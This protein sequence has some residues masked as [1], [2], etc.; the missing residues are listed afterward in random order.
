MARARRL[1][2][3]YVLGEA[4]RIVKSYDTQVTLRQLFYRLVSAEIIEN[5]QSRYN[6]LSARSAQARRDGWFPSLID[7]NRNMGGHS[8]W[9]SPEQALRTIAKAYTRDRTEHQVFG[10]YVAVEKNA[11][12]GLLE[13][14]FDELGVAIV[15]LGGYA[16]QT[17]CD[18]VAEDVARYGRDAVLI[19][20]GD[21]DPSGLDIQRDFEARTDCWHSV[22]R[23]ALS[24]EQ[25][26]QYN[27]PPL[28]GK[29]SDSRAAGFVAEHGEL[30]QVEL[31]ALPPDVL[32]SLY[33]AGID[34]WWNDEAYEQSLAQEEEERGWLTGLRF[35]R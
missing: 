20:G 3:D 28:P 14:W 26:E 12:R 22:E 4:A 33:Q 2:W 8:G 9:D 6:S 19:Y 23:V 16:S 29:S 5:T 17:Y 27:L 24:W 18:D 30:V 13:S 34:E 11:L 25:I 32:R 1:D 15:A 10:I 21:F 31:D 7:N 35:E